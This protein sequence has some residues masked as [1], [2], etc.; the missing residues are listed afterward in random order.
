M[1]ENASTRSAAKPAGPVTCTDTPSGTPPR[2]CSPTAT[3]T[4][5]MSDAASIGTNAWIARPSSDGI[6]GETAS[7]TPSISGRSATCC[8]TVS[9]ASASNPSSEVKTTIAGMASESLNSPS[10]A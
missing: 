2:S 8:P 6:A 10:R 5:S 1:P 3:T 4:S 7:A 9:V